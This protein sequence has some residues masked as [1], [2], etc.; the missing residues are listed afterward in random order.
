MVILNSLD[1]HKTE[2]KYEY[3]HLKT[4]QASK[5]ISFSWLI[6]LRLLLVM[7]SIYTCDALY[8]LMM[9][10]LCFVFLQLIRYHAVLLIFFIEDH[11]MRWFKSYLK[12]SLFI[13]EF[14]L[15][16]LSVF[17]LH[18]YFVRAIHNQRAVRLIICN[19]AALIKWLN[20]LY[21]LFLS[22]LWV[23]LR[24]CT[25]PKTNFYYFS[26][27]FTRLKRSISCIS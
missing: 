18:I 17:P 4:T 12:L 23:K 6:T 11:S 21:K 5:P 8:L 7:V 24:N 16:I 2:A 9:L 20:D 25:S 13:F 3:V 15:I 14:I 26:I 10:Y 1:N 22:R 27:R 19:S